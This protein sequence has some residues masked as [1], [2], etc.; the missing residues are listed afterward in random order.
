MEVVL[1]PLHFNHFLLANFA[2]RG[3]ARVGGMEFDWRYNYRFPKFVTS[4]SK[5]LS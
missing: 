3:Y 1:V 4:I 5:G 2:L